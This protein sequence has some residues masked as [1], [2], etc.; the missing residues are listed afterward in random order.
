MSETRFGAEIGGLGTAGRM[1]RSARYKYCV[2]NWGKYREQLFDLKADPGE[3]LNLAV[4]AQ[5]RDVL[6]V[7]TASYLRCGPRERTT[8]TPLMKRT[9]TRFRPCLDKSIGGRRIAGKPR[10]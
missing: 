10:L 9:L 3:M 8:A 2:Y 4:E 1:V 7:H 5:Y 6:S